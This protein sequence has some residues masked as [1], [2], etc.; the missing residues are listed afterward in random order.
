MADA[1]VLSDCYFQRNPGSKPNGV[2][3]HCCEGETNSI[4]GAFH[5]DPISKGTKDSDVRLF[6]H[7]YYT[8]GIM[9]ENF[10]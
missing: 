2:L 10:A 6:T 4:F 3:E 5:S 7:I 8:T 9:P 1:P